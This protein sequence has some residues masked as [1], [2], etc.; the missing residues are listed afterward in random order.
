MDSWRE[1]GIQTK[2]VWWNLS[3]IK[4]TTPQMVAGGS[5]FMSGLSPMLLKYLSVGFNAEI[6]LDTLLEEY[7]KKISIESTAAEVALGEE[8]QG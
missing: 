8:L 5:I 2:I 1:R 7:K 3:T 4:A 6:F